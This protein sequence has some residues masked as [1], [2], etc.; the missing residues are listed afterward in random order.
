MNIDL[1]PNKCKICVQAKQHKKHFKTVNGDSRESR[2]D[3][4]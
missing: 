3:S 4:Q 1:I 2:S